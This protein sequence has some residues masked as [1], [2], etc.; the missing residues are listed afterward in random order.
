M[1]TNWQL[2]NAHQRWLPGITLM[3]LSVT[4]CVHVK[5][6]HQG[7]L[8]MRTTQ[9]GMR[10]ELELRWLLP[11]A[12]VVDSR[13]E[14]TR[15]TMCTHDSTARHDTPNGS[16][17]THGERLAGHPSHSRACTSTRRSNELQTTS[18]K[19]KRS[20]PASQVQTVCGAVPIAPRERSDPPVGDARDTVSTRP[21]N[22]SDAVSSIKPFAPLRVWRHH[23]SLLNLLES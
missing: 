11:L 21:S 9:C 5:G 20:N 22:L 13:Q 23:A 2:A 6:P 1:L 12:A 18:V 17:E 10:W 14:D 4:V 15:H 8:R 19:V 7:Q 3:S 16:S